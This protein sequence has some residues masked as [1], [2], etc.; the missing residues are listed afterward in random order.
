MFNNPSYFRAGCGA[1][2]AFPFFGNT[3][4]S[5]SY[6]WDPAT[7]AEVLW[8]HA[9][10]DQE[11]AWVIGW[12]SHLAMDG[13][14]HGFANTYAALAMK[15]HVKAAANVNRPQVW[16]TFTPSNFL[17][18]IAAE[19][20]V[21]SFFVYAANPASTKLDTPTEFA[22]RMYLSRGSPL[23]QHYSRLLS[24]WKP[25][26]TGDIKTKIAG[27]RPGVLATLFHRGLEH[28]N[29]FEEYHTQQQYL[30]TG[31]MKFYDGKSDFDGVLHHFV[32]KAFS[33]WH[34][35]RVEKIQNIYKAWTT[36]TVALQTAVSARAGAE[37]LLKA[38]KPLDTA[39][40]AYASI[41][42]LSPEL[43]PAPVRKMYE[44]V[45]TFFKHI[46][47]AVSKVVK[48]IVM[49]VL[50]PVIAQ[51]KEIAQ[52]ASGKLIDRSLDK[53]ARNHARGLLARAGLVR[54][55]THGEPDAKGIFGKEV[56][57]GIDG[58]KDAGTNIGN[59]TRLMQY[60]FYRNAFMGVVGV[61]GDQNSIR[62]LPSADFTNGFRCTDA[63]VN[64]RK[65]ND[66]RFTGILKGTDAWYNATVEA[67]HTPQFTRV[68][69]RAFISYDYVAQYSPLLTSSKG[70]DFGAMIATALR[71]LAGVL[72]QAGDWMWGVTKQITELLLNK[73]TTAI[74][75]LWTGVKK[76][77]DK[78]VTNVTGTVNAGVRKVT[79]WVGFQLCNGKCNAENVPFL[80]CWKGRSTC[81][82]RRKS[83][84]EGCDNRF[85]K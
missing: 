23:R 22:Q 9:K 68:E 63:F 34:Q 67:C 3:D 10:T 74:V 18:H 62:N 83:C 44:A 38:M 37:D 8:E 49:K 13:A 82:A 47:E 53:N 79:D 26:S 81:D 84:F 30:W 55:A 14:V 72:G 12:K 33:F 66:G 70:F 36:T 41:D 50:E 58:A 40:S 2:D 54:S 56:H 71:G 31:H 42:L 61:L 52:V 29:Q 11:K 35:H 75:H 43:I 69:S 21:N 25:G 64:S 76:E 5:H 24:V 20:W 6:G 19:S 17:G 73:A 27:E 80:T 59:R 32:A 51:V 16:D 78:V 77:I 39:V 85:K 60:P 7:Q 57:A 4:P 65:S 28:L 1:P 46:Q 45:K 48:E 15:R